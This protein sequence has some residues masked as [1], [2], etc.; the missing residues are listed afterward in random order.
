MYPSQLL[1]DNWMH[2]YD[3]TY[4]LWYT[5]GGLLVTKEIAQAL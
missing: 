4:S 3:G 5:L 2:V 1:A